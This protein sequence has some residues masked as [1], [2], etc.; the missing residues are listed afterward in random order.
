M[1]LLLLLLVWRNAAIARNRESAEPERAPR[2]GHR[3]LRRCGS[4]PRAL[5]RTSSNLGRNALRNV[6]PAVSG[7]FGQEAPFFL[8]NSLTWVFFFSGTLRDV[9]DRVRERAFG[10]ILVS[11]L[12]E[13]EQRAK[14]DAARRALL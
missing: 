1:L 6:A 13:L 14:S 4:E 5:S 11:A 10:E 3:E 8:S 7:P 9:L 2:A 12:D